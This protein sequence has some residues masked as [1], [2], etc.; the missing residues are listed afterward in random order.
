MDMKYPES[1]NQ[2]KLCLESKRSPN[3]NNVI[4]SEASDLLSSSRNIVAKTADSS[5]A[6]LL[7]AIWFATLG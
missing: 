7:M 4:T 3:D 2:P 5:L 1:L 6:A